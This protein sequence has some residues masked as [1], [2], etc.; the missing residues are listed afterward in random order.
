MNGNFGCLFSYR[1]GEAT[2][3][4][5]N[6]LPGTGLML[7]L[8]GLPTT[9]VWLKSKRQLPIV[10]GYRRALLLLAKFSVLGGMAAAC[11]CLIFAA[12]DQLGLTHF[13][14]PAVSFA[15]IVPAIVI[16]D[17]IQRFLAKLLRSP[18]YSK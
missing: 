11:L 9:I 1:N 5:A 10:T 4:T 16:G 8:V 18:E 14:Y 6:F 13:G 17:G 12:L 7:L 2:S 3:A 15:A